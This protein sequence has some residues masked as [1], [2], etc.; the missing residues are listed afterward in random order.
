MLKCVDLADVELGM[1]VHKMEGNWFDHPFWKGN[2]LIDDDKRL[3]QLKS[4]KLRAVIIDTSKGKDVSAPVARRAAA[5]PAPAA[6]ARDRL[7]TIRKRTS[8]ETASTKACTI[9]EELHAADAIATKAN[10]N[11]HKTFMAARVGRALNLKAIAPVVTDILASVKRNPQAFSGLMRCKLKNEVMFRHALS[12]SALMVAL[13]ARMRLP[14]EDI[15]D[16]GLAGLLLDIG[17]NY[18]PANLDPPDGDYRNIDPRLWQ[19]H[20]MLGYRAL[21][22][23]DALQQRVL[24]AVLQHH[25][26]MDGSGFPMGVAAEKIPLFARMAAICDTFDF[27]LLPTNSSAGLDPASAIRHMRAMTGAF[28]DQLLNRFIESVGLYPIGSFVRLRS[29]K[30]AMVI[31]EDLKDH[32]RPV[33]QAFYSLATGEQLVPHRIALAD[34]REQDQIVDIADLR[35]LDLP[36]PDHLREM[37]F[38][39]T[40]RNN[41]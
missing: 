24:D 1:F 19:Q 9:T 40:Y 33:V 27:L 7:H 10:D 23:D 21:S 15:Y 30:L 32:T 6:T 25:E 14:A 34:I 16:C 36:G 5:S 18:L 35:G 31:D 38:L 3:Q 20:T 2:F 11:L 26:R 29:D 4:S 22:H 37:M 41:A 39:S 8:R 12:V 28:D 17:V 13:A